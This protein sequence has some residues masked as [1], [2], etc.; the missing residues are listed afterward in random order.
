MLGV[1][2]REEVA[3]VVGVVEVADSRLRGWRGQRTWLACKG[4][5]STVACHTLA[6]TSLAQAPGEL[7]IRGCLV[8]PQLDKTLHRYPS[9]VSRF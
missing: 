1:N 7:L 3:A 5:I 4:E 2:S 8:K 9:S 6:D